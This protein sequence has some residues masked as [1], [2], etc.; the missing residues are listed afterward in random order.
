[1]ATVVKLGRVVTS[2]Y[3]DVTRFG[4]SNRSHLVI[5][6]VTAA[7]AGLYLC[8]EDDGFGAKHPVVLFVLGDDGKTR[9]DDLFG[10]LAIPTET[11]TNLLTGRHY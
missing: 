1:M 2:R 7:D 9:F 5:S 6:D 10:S 3:D 8:T 4:V 11:N